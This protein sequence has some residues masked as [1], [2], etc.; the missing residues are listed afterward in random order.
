LSRVIKGAVLIEDGPK[1]IKSIL[2]EWEEKKRIEAEDASKEELVN[3]EAEKAALTLLIEERRR[4]AERM[5]DDARLEAGAILAKAQS[6][7]N[8]LIDETKT[9]AKMETEAMKQRVYEEFSAKGYEE[10]H[11][12]GYKA[13]RDETAEAVREANEKAQRTL[14]LAEGEAGKALQEA[15]KK[16]V[17]LTLAI[18]R[19]IVPQIFEDMP[20]TI[21]REVQEALKKVRDQNEIKLKV[22]EDDYEIVLM[23]KEEFRSMLPSDSRLEIVTDNKIGRGGCIIESDSGNVDARLSTKMEAVMK[24]IQEAAGE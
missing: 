11:D 18:V 19:K 22:S 17:E 12:R 10:G 14:K 24:A 6:Q 15:E 23:A 13:G 20:Q 4:Q 3:I 9:Q 8:D 16:M 21:L 7:A 2:P 1:I 5:V